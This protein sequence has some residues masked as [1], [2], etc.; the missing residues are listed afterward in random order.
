MLVNICVIPHMHTAFS[1][2]LVCICFA[3]DFTVLTYGNN[4][5]IKVVSLNSFAVLSPKSS[6]KT[7]FC[8]N[9]GATTHAVVLLYGIKEP[10]Q[11]SRNRLNMMPV[12]LKKKRH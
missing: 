11:A 5:Q 1:M 9:A 12:V 10:F 4:S 7:C 8:M 6:K 2:L 3:S